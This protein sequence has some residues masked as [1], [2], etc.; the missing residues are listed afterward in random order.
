MC[1]IMYR[2]VA[3]LCLA[4]SV[5]HTGAILTTLRV[6][7]VVCRTPATVTPSRYGLGLQRASAP[8]R[9][10]QVSQALGRDAVFVF[11]ECVILLCREC[12]SYVDRIAFEQN[13]KQ[14]EVL[15][16]RTISFRAKFLI[17]HDSLFT[18]DVRSFLFNSSRVYVRRTVPSIFSIRSKVSRGRGIGGVA[19]SFKNY[20]G[21][22]NSLGSMI[23]LR[24]QIKFNRL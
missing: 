2:S 16:N 22:N 3:N 18:D 17:F 11:A 7:R 24:V 5:T 9:R 8:G 23:V 10:C 21:I 19:N 20:T 15:N 4:L 13:K 6:D 12:V 14:V 1:C